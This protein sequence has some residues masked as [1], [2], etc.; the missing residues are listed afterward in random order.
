MTARFSAFPRAAENFRAKAV[1]ADTGTR[2]D[3]PPSLTVNRPRE[4]QT[5]TYEPKSRSWV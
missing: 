3:I 2:K 5:T 1:I 4:A